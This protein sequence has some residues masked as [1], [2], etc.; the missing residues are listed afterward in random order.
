MKHSAAHAP[1]LQTWP[2]PQL[3]PV[4]SFDHAVVDDDGLQTWQGFAGLTVPD[5]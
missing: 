2:A 1:A 5:V 4:G 3:W